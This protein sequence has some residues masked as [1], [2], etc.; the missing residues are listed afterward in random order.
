MVKYINKDLDFLTLYAIMDN[1][2]RFVFSLSLCLS[3]SVY[4]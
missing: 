3:S 1:V 4:P 2:M